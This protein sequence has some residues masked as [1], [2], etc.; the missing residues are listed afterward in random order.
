M[1][2]ITSARVPWGE[3]A[4]AAA[5][6]PEREVFR[7]KRR[8]A[9]ESWSRASLL[10]RVE[11]LGQRFSER[12]PYPVLIAVCGEYAP[13]L[14]TVALAGARLGAAVVA[15]PTAATQSL[16]T[17]WLQRARPD[18]VYVGLREQLGAWEAALRQAGQAP[19]VVADFH[20][21]WGG[22]KTAA[23][24]SAAELFGRLPEPPSVRPA[25]RLTWIEEATDWADGLSFVLHVIAEAGGSFAFPESRAA[26]GRDRRELR[27]HALALSAA[28]HVRLQHDLA[29]RL[30]AGGGP[31]ARLTNAALKAAEGGRADVHHRALL[32]RIR[33]PL[34]LSRVDELTVVGAAT[35]SGIDLFAALGIRAGRRVAPEQIA[36]NNSQLAFA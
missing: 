35:E 11:Q 3:F 18:L 2:D 8:G 25:D 33:E 26:A 14:L 22:V 30:P 13:R 27:P 31:V 21:P 32:R 17:A 10:A 7:H 15:V 28:H 4:A 1:V 23:V 19:I 24:T 20:L 34:G 6:D 36:P 9:W 5:S 16:L 12:R 29:T